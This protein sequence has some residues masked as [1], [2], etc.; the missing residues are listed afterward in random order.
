MAGII[1]SFP[2]EYLPLARGNSWLISAL[3]LSV[4]DW[5]GEI[6]AGVLCLWYWQPPVGGEKDI[7][8]FFPCQ[9]VHV[10]REGGKMFNWLILRKPVSGRK[11]VCLFPPITIQGR[12]W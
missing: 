6:M 12:K 3:P 2:N 4:S 10:T 7:N 9:S 1:A 11:G 5:K 8:K